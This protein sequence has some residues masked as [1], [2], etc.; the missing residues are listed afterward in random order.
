MATLYPRKDS[1]FF[2]IKY[3]G[4]NGRIIQESTGCRKHMAID[5]RRAKALEAERTAEE[6]RRN[7]PVHTKREQGWA[8]VR[9]FL[10]LRNGAREQT[11]NHNL[12]CW[13]TMEMFLDEKKIPSPANLTREHCFDYMTWRREPKPKQGKFFACHNTALHEVKLL[14]SVAQEAVNRGMLTANPCLRLNIGKQAVKKKP[15]LTEADCALIRASIAKETD[16]AIRDFLSNS[17]EIARHQGCRI[18][19]TS[20]NPQTD[21]EI[22]KGPGRNNKRGLITFLAKGGKRFTTVLHP[23][24]IPLFERLK[25]Q[26][27]TRTWATPEGRVFSWASG[28]WFRFLRRIGLKEKGV[29]FHCTRVTVIS[30]LARNDVHISKAK[31][32]V[33]HASTAIHEIYQRLNVSDVAGVVRFVASRRGKR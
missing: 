20:L 31:S 28:Y 16:P 14:G 21:V 3:R 15:E 12:R 2:W 24:L 27:K 30:E 22:F 19:E 23:N 29:T 25:A 6:L 32:F 33:G 11:M 7:V 18:T 5:I 4:K 9:D 10:R 13:T 8:W 17:F 1:P 26:G